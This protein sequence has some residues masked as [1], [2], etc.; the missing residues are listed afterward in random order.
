MNKQAIFCNRKCT[1]DLL[2][3]TSAIFENLYCSQKILHDITYT[4][5][6]TGSRESIFLLVS[7]TLVVIQ[8]LFITKSDENLAIFNQTF[9]YEIGLM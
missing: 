7:K 8:N 4:T 9:L 6:S 5:V 2:S 1:H 3:L